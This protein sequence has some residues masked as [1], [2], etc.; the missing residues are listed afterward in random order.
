MAETEKRYGDVCGPR[1]SET[2]AERLTYCRTM[3]Y[4]YDWLT[5]AENERVYH[6]GQR[7]AWQEKGATDG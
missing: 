2:L 1:Q 3:L 4:L 6:R 7:L 5:D